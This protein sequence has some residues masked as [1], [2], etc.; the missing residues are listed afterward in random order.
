M[1]FISHIVDGLSP[2]S[3]AKPATAVVDLLGYDG[4]PA[5]YGLTQIASGPWPSLI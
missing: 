4:W 2:T 5:V 3:A 1:S